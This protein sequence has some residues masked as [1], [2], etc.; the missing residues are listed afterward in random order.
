MVSGHSDE[1]QPFLRLPS[2][3]NDSDSRVMIS[4]QSPSRRIAIG[5]VSLRTIELIGVG[6]AWIGLTGCNATAP[7][8]PVSAPATDTAVAVQVVRPPT[9][10]SG[11][12]GSQVCAEC[13]QE[14]ATAFRS[15]SMARSLG[16]IGQVTPIEHD[17]D[18]AEFS[19]PGDRTYQV[20]RTPD[21]V[22]HHEIRRNAAGEVLY[23][24]RVPVQY[25]VGSG[26]RGRSY[27]TNR[28]GLLF[29]SSIGWYSEGHR[30][31]LSPGYR[32]DS[33]QRFDR[34]VSDGC[35]AC[36]AGRMNV[37]AG[38][39]NRYHPQ[40]PFLEESIGCERC[41]GPGAD[42]VQHYRDRREGPDSIV[43]PAKLD[44][45]R[46]DAVCNQCHLQGTRRLT[47]YG[48]SEFDF[49]PGDRLTDLWVVNLGQEKSGRQEDFAAVTQ[50]EQM[51][52]STCF[53]ESRQ[54]VCTT[55]HDPHRGIPASERASFY[56]SRCASC[57][58]DGATTCSASPADRR[59][60]S[61]IDCH[62]P[63]MATSNV[64]H[65]SQSDHR[66][67]RTPGSQPSKRASDPVVLYQEDAEALPEWETQ[68]ATGLI[69]ADLAERQS[70]YLL[71]RRAL[72]LLTPLESALVGDVP[73]LQAL[74]GASRQVE[75]YPK[76]VRY[77]EA[78]LNI[79]PRNPQLL[80]SLGL[81][82]HYQGDFTRAKQY[83]Q[84]LLAVNGWRA[85]Y[86]GRYSHV[87]GKLG[88]WDAAIV[89]GK[90]CVELNPQLTHV[91]EWLAEAYERTGQPGLAAE[92][93]AL[94]QRAESK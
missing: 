30:W 82:Y 69:L 86:F 52:E 47:R 78:G 77:W 39:P 93:R 92:Q 32:P 63:R 59:S 91:H 42:H 9:P 23:D 51:R 33:H 73:L 26:V 61:C 7:P 22:F 15:H 89:A 2:H 76:A 68:R 10:R 21:G 46:Q 84:R 48:R 55:C 67:P 11:Y 74:G 79:D 71:A 16:E 70:N 44:L 50:A 64:P 28:D 19:P 37:V 83:Y 36:H 66:I 57:H 4:Q 3:Q 1:L 38:E 49:R 5:R 25:A 27:L 6:L 24:Q 90:R 94:Q 17:E 34:Q 41:H 20:E 8:A 14:I 18:R 58:H 13:H 29:M 88:E 75:D 43:N 72:Q 35:L 80:E 45:V 31:D 85:E 60:Q 40:Q 81:Y 56:E 54:L 65:T 87:L 12:V 62:M 53:R